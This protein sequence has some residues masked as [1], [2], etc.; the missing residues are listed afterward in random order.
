MDL[1]NDENITTKTNPTIPTSPSS[2]N[3]IKSSN[4]K[5]GNGI[6]WK[7]GN[8][9]IITMEY[10]EICDFA[11]E[12]DEDGFPSQQDETGIYYDKIPQQQH[13]HHVFLKRKIYFMVI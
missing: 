1:R 2:S 13:Q 8:P 9:I 11:I 4:L 6:F 3:P 5:I 7:M 12:K 10:R